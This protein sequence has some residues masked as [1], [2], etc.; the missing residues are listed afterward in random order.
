MILEI[1]TIKDRAVGAFL[2]PFFSPTLQSATRSLVQ[3]LQ[4]PEHA[5]H[6]NAED[7]TLYRVGTFDDATGECIPDPLG[8]ILIT[9]L[10]RLKTTVSSPI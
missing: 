5:F 10:V 2:Q 8:P 1:Y 7:Y 3:V 4:D 6:K 9:P